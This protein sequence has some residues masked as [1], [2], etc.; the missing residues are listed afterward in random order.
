MGSIKVNRGTVFSETP[1]DYFLGITLI[2]KRMTD[3]LVWEK[4]QSV[5]AAAFGTSMASTIESDFEKNYSAKNLKRSL[6]D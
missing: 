3:G 6:T 5:F 4:S 2:I 1:S